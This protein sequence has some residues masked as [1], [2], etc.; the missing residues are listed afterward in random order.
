M[1]Q[2]PEVHSFENAFGIAMHRVLWWQKQE[3]MG[4]DVLVIAFDNKERLTLRD[5]K[6]IA[7][8]EAHFRRVGLKKGTV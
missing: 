6:K 1:I 7:E 3:E 2:I 8:A 4:N 5:P